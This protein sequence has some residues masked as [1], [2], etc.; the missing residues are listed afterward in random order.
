MA[1]PTTM[2][3][4][5]T[6]AASN[7]PAGSESPTNADDHLRA[8]YAILRTTNAKGSDIASASTTDIG[9]A[10]GEFVDVT[11]TTTITSLGTV[12]A[13]IV[14]TVR[15]TGALTLTHNATSLILPG[16][17][18]ITTAANDRAE[19]RSLGSGNW[20]CVEYI[21][22]DGSPVARFKG[23]AV[24]SA[25]TTDIWAASAETVH[26]T[27][28]TAITSFGTAG[29][30]GLMRT[31]VIDSAGV[32]IT[33]GANLICPEGVDIVSSAGDVI[34]IVADTT[35]Q[36]RVKSYARAG[37]LHSIG[38]FTRDVSLASGTQVITGVGFKPKRVFFQM[39]LTST[40]ASIS[41][42]GWDDGSSRFCVYD[43]HLSTADS[44]AISGNFSIILSTAN[45]YTG[46]ITALSSDGFTITW[47]RNGAPTGTITIR[48]IAEM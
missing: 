18:N 47:T 14:R 35:T 11:G 9:A 32:V 46:L 27:G 22:A 21:R 25:S 45:S 44:N 15:F 38:S 19:F 31:L 40:V 33:H 10:T 24:A 5:S 23:T 7:S 12:A 34:E 36:H 20:L 28:T 43:N 42:A 37:S 2:A 17:A 30:A 1:V 16:A 4:L 13:G 26:I 6:T 39:A 3:E 48:Y 29:R 8:A 41:S